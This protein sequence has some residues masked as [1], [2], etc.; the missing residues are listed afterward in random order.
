MRDPAVFP[1]TDSGRPTIDW[2]AWTGE[3]VIYRQIPS[4]PIDWTKLPEL[5]VLFEP[6]IG[7][8]VVYNPYAHSTTGSAQPFT[9]SVERAKQLWQELY[10]RQP[11][12][13]QATVPLAKIVEAFAQAWVRRGGTNLA[14]RQAMLQLM[15]KKHGREGD[16]QMIPMLRWTYPF[17]LAGRPPQAGPFLVI[18]DRALIP[19]PPTELMRVDRTAWKPGLAT[20][21]PNGP[22]YSNVGATP[23]V[24]HTVA[25]TIDSAK[26]FPAFS[27]FDYQSHPDQPPF[28]PWDYLQDVPVSKAMH[29]STQPF[30]LRRYARRVADLWQARTGHRPAVYATTALSLNGRPFQPVVNPDADLAAVSVHWFSH[31]PW[32]LDLKEKRIPRDRALPGFFGK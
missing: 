25:F 31:N 24:I 26:M 6:V 22:R 27:I 2:N 15:L 21:P 13:F 3:K 12:S 1:P 8:R 16:G 19:Q 28:V 29:I 14:D 4:G 32:I 18:E 20:Q 9:E 11:D 30:I 10:G 7:E 17:E 5:V 23:L